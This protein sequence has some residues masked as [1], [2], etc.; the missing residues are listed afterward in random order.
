MIAYE[1]SI[2]VIK[3]SFKSQ[4]LLWVDEGQFFIL[5]TLLQMEKIRSGCMH[6]LGK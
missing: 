3:L 1:Y 5:A 6:G 2:G 4:S